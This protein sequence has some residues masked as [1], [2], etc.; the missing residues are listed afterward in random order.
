MMARPTLPGRS[1][2]YAAIAKYKITEV[3]KV[4]FLQSET[5]KTV[6]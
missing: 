4:T 2:V 3:V 1:E 6:R 5:Y